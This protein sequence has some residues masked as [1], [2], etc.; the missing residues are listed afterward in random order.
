MK[1]LNL[2]IVEHHG[3][4]IE[5]SSD[6]NVYVSVEVEFGEVPD[7]PVYVETQLLCLKDDI[8]I[9]TSELSSSEVVADSSRVYLSDSFH[10]GNGQIPDSYIVN[11]RAFIPDEVCMIDTPIPPEIARQSGAYLIH[12]PKKGFLSREKWV[13]GAVSV[14]SIVVKNVAGEDDALFVNV[15]SLKPTETGF[16]ITCTSGESDDYTIFKILEKPQTASDH[17][18]VHLT[19]DLS[20]SLTGFSSTEWFISEKSAFVSTREVEEESDSAEDDAEYES[21][22]YESSSGIELE[23]GL[24]DEAPIQ[25]TTSLRQSIATD[26]S[27]SWIAASGKVEN[28]L[29]EDLA[30]TITRFD[31][32]APDDD[33]DISVDLEFEIKNESDRDVSLIKYDVVIEQD[34]V[35][36]IGG[37]TRNTEDCLLDAGEV[38]SGS[39]WLRI[40]ENLM[41]KGN[42][43]VS[44]KLFARV[45][46]REFFKIG[47]ID[48][49]AELNDPVS[50]V[51]EIDSELLDSRI[52]VAMMRRSDGDEESN[53]DL[54]EFKT[55]ITNKTDGYIEDIEV[56]VVL[57]DR[58][59]AEDDDTYDSLD[60]LGPHSGTYIEPSFWGKPKSKLKGATVDIFL[61]AH[62]LIGTRVISETRRLSS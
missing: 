45:Y 1:K 16:K 35:G 10:A 48:V 44:V 6:G 29:I 23:S 53:E 55:S 31:C 34:G 37:Q 11:F 25:E 60:T 28:E 59:G 54:L 32:E 39:S 13:S 18:R 58:T 8:I 4:E 50:L 3:S 47:S 21:D 61:K 49:P 22:E 57:L 40:N 9:S 38:F 42:S 12:T 30:M 26:S 24:L 2:S 17:L 5:I 20:V 52:T 27:D 56:R 41:T 33:G 43:E 51:K 19:G 36:P 46:E 7:T 15:S 14:D 62:R